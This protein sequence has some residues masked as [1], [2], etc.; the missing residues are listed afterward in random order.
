MKLLPI[1]KAATNDI[2]AYNNAYNE[3]VHSALAT[4]LLSQIVYWYPKSTYPG[5][6]FYKT[7]EEWTRELGM[8]R[9]EQRRTRKIL[10][11]LGLIEYQVR[12]TPPK[13][14]YR[15][16]KKLS[17][18]MFQDATEKPN[19]S[20]KGRN[21]LIDV[22]ERAIQKD[23]TVLCKGRNVQNNTY[24]TA[25]TSN[26]EYKQRNLLSDCE[27][28]DCAPNNFSVDDFVKRWSEISKKYKYPSVKV[29]NSSLASAFD[30]V[31]KIIRKEYLPDDEKPW[32]TFFKN[33]E[34]IMLEYLFYDFRQY[35]NPSYALRLT[36]KNDNIAK[37]CNYNG[38]GW[39]PKDNRHADLKT[40]RKMKEKFREDICKEKHLQTAFYETI[41]KLEKMKKEDPSIKIK[42]RVRKNRELIDASRA[43]ISKMS[44]LLEECD[45]FLNDLEN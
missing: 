14:F 12:G 44:V 28:S 19:E 17:D 32:D 45:T 36:G 29:V 24:T 23:E 22:S 25:K 27:Q 30:K 2:R 21:R 4:L 18:W 35:F 20:S 1:P 3:L 26:K 6:W 16:T 15:I 42:K 41:T 11:D 7:T 13:A 9:S 43:R 34:A 5:G 8:N 10:L 37:I 38:V 39:V 33:V 31:N 40:C